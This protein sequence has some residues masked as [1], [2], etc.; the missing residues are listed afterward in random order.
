MKK[1]KMK[2]IAIITIFIVMCIHVG[3]MKSLATNENLNLYVKEQCD[4]V[5]KRDGKVLRIS[6]VVYQKDG[7]EY[8][9]YCLN[10]EKPGVGE[11]GTYD[12]NIQEVINDLSIWRVMINGYPYQ[13]PSQLGCLNEKEAFAATKMAIYSVLYGYSIEQFS[14]IGEEGQRIYNALNKFCKM[15]RIVVQ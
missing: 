1:I 6:F 4:G 2:L 15:Q 11:I 13:I 3:S 5:L 8:P 12:V 14:G 7:K 9:A 10:K